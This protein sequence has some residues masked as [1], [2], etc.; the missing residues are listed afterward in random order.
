MQ[1]LSTQTVRL[2]KAEAHLRGGRLRDAELLYRQVLA[3]VPQHVDA[4]RGLARVAERVGR[5]DAAALI[6]RQA[7]GTALDHAALHAHLG[8]VYRKLGRWDEAE[9]FCARAT[10]LDATLVDAWYNLGVVAQMQGRFDAA[11][12]H[13]ERVVKLDDR[14]G[15]GWYNLGHVLMAIEDAVGAA[16]CFERASALL[17][18]EAEPWVNLGLAQEKLGAK[19]Q[20]L[21]AFERALA[22]GVSARVRYHIAA[23]TGRDVPADAP[24]EHVAAVF[25]EM[26]ERFDRHLVDKLNYHV[27]EKLTALLLHQ[28]AALGAVA[29]LGCGTGLCGPLV[30]PYA[31]H[32]VGVDL[33]PAMVAKAQSRGHYDELHVGEMVAFLQARP[34]AFDVILAADVLVYVGD[35]EP[36]FAAVRRA[37]R[38]GGLWA[39]SV[40]RHDGPGYQL[41]ATRRY[42]HGAAYVRDA[43]HGFDILAFQ[44]ES[45][46]R[47]AR[48][49]VTGYLAV[50]RAPAG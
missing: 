36:L 44:E 17:P 27:P 11:Q 50:L 13:Y 30:K 42:A 31:K 8:E 6:L 26:A 47:E 3:E 45:L 10:A 43:A 38:P 2:E 12:A 35:L 18:H 14:H 32:L 5:L 28:R 16:R 37:L 41:R 48:E 39:F 21:A 22:L 40:E 1:D 19:D 34:A 7:V 15:A 23:L 4:M 29:D 24:P 20:A 49:T 25:D 33:S 9:A 46:R